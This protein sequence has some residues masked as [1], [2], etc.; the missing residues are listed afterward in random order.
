MVK[1]YSKYKDSGTSWIGAIPVH[2]KTLPGKA[3]FYE[4][5]VPNAGFI[6]KQVLSLSYGSIIIKPEE[7]LHGLVPESFETYQVVD[8][9]DIICRP[10]DLQNDWVSLRFGISRNR[11]IITSAYISLK[12]QDT[13]V[14][15]FG[16][17][18]L[19]V[20]DLKKVFYGLG[21]G[22]RQNLGWEDFR[23]LPCISPPIEEQESI[24]SFIHSANK[25]INQYIRLKQKL[26]KLLNEQKQGIINQ[27]VTRGVDTK[28]AFKPSGFEWLGNIPEH[29]ETRRIRSCI[30][31]VMAGVWGDDPTEDNV[32]DHIICVR[33][34]DFDMLELKISRKKLTTRAIPI[35][36][37]QT[38]ALRQDD[39][40]IEK[41][42]GGDAQPVGRA[43]IFDLNEPAVSSNFIS[44][45]RVNQ[46]LIRPRFFLYILTILQSRRHNLLS[47]KQTTGIQNLDDKH[48][49]SNTIG[50]PPLDEQDRIVKTIEEQI[51]IITNAQQKMGRDIE[52]IKEYRTRLVSDVVT[53]KIDVRDVKLQEL[54]EEVLQ[55]QIDQQEISEDIEDSEEVV[56]ADE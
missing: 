22:L 24:I 28:V 45:I 41:S 39:I 56:N 4:K 18:L 5:R 37:R 34:A 3:C 2:W 17:L 48:Y 10:T 8:P 47:I 55:E 40:L 42:G 11:G 23:Y 25:A 12:T 50:M 14:P 27:A 46:K 32:D 31:S 36:A 20:Y 1:A 30:E 21:S 16:Y 49:F 52:L 33:V 44:R 43:V 7:K 54:K 6:E 51:G 26:I 29:W 9:F 38:R 19:H 15:E 35:N 13:L 53:G